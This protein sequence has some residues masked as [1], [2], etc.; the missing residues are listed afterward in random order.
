MRDSVRLSAM[1]LSVACAVFAVLVGIAAPR[2]QSHAREVMAA[3]T[4]NWST[5]A[6]PRDGLRVES[7]NAL[8]DGQP[9]TNVTISGRGASSL[10]PPGLQRWPAQGETVPSPAL[11]ALARRDRQVAAQLG[12]LASVSIGPAGL[13]APD[14]LFSYTAAPRATTTAHAVGQSGSPVVTGFGGETSAPP[15]SGNTMLLIEVVVLIL[16]PAALF[17]VTAMR[18]SAASRERRS[19][20]LGLMGMSP[21]R[22]ARLYSWEMSVLA[23]LGF[24]L[25][26]GAY[27]ATEGWL[28]ESGWLG[29]RWWPDQGRLSTP[30]ALVAGAITVGLVRS[31]AS[32]VMRVA[33]ERSRSQRE[34]RAQPVITILGALIGIPSFGFL[35]ATVLHGWLH[36]SDAYADGRF[37]ALIAG[38]IVGCVLGV[39]LA[40]PPMIARLGAAVADY[41]H[42]AVA[43]GLRGAANR[44]A[45]SRRLIAF[46]ACAVMLA[47]LSA[48][49]AA[50]LWRGAFGDPGQATISF[51]I[52][53]AA[54]TGS[55]WYS[56]LPIGPMTIETS[57]GGDSGSYDVVIGDCPAV[58]RQARVVFPH[59]GTCTD[60]TQR[61]DGGIGG[62]TVG[63][64]NVAGLAVRVPAG[65]SV[66][67]YT[68]DLK[69]PPDKAPWA[70]RLTDGQVT[71]WV[72]R[73]DGSYQR[74]LAALTHAFPGLALEGG[75]NDPD[76]Y[77]AYQQQVGVV[78]A[79]AT[80]G[81][82]MSVCSF[83]LTALEN[84]WSRARSVSALVA[85]GAAKR[86]LRIAN[87]V[88]FVYPVVGAVLPAA[89]V[90]V[91]GGW[92]VLSFFGSSGMFVASVPLWTVIGSALTVV[93]AALG[94]WATGYTPFQRGSVSDT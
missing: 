91:L 8:L 34:A 81:L 39:I 27:N 29:V 30:V 5:N 10:L 83:L 23:A 63:R 43:L 69:Y 22:N 67:H 15:P 78:R 33:A 56:K 53:E 44:T 36:P 40:A 55:T 88:E 66:A 84:R 61:S 64:L 85:L 54:G 58:L 12:P 47:G 7:V 45:S 25:G 92:A 26:A 2:S 89:I 31:I 21:Q 20:L 35:A 3:R 16:T 32:R 93:T 77:A 49:F 75:L 74:T 24:G 70:G 65:G 51:E 73:A 9:W 52:A 48:A 86:D 28:G 80:L 50:A 82:W 46:V 18:L 14:E 17:L 59:P 79:A 6:G 68:W 19:F 87:T 90:G 38:A 57:I 72:S 4:P 76:G 11:R 94:G 37:A 60:T 41:A 42:P 1:V 71:Y 13:T 62:L